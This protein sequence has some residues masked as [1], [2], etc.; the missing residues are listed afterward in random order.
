MHSH[1][2]TQHTGRNKNMPL[3][4]SQC[5]DIVKPLKGSPLS[6]FVTL[7]LFGGSLTGKELRIITGYSD[8]AVTNATTY[9][10]MREAI[11]N[12]GKNSGWSIR[13]RDQLPLP[14]QQLAGA[15]LELSTGYPQARKDDPE[16]PDQLVKSSRKNK[17]D[18]EK[19][20]QLP[21]PPPIYI[22]RKEGEERP[23]AAKTFALCIS[24]RVG[25]AMAQKIAETRDYD[26]VLAMLN[27]YQA[28]GKPLRFALKAIKDNDP[29]ELHVDAETTCPTC[30]KVIDH[31]LGY[32]A[33]CEIINRQTGD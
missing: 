10:E 24:R 29:V 32:C 1:Y 2:R 18:P 21:P 11:Q 8:E 16:K 7:V 30:N 19:P 13:Q 12:N 25:V 6:I 9:L 5:T 22:L 20:D 23:D 4:M 31:R 27:Q 33:P 3:S 17:V 26:Y 15:V 28:W 14:F